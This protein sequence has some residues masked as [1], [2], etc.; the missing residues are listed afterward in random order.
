MTI[1]PFINFANV[2]IGPAGA[3]VLA[4]PESQLDPD[5]GIEVQLRLDMSLD[6]FQGL[7]HIGHVQSTPQAAMQ[8]LATTSQITLIE[9]GEAGPVRVHRGVSVRSQA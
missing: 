8:A 5:M 6:L 3:I 4:V 1:E 2:V 7:N 9:V